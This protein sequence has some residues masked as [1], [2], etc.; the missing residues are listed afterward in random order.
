MLNGDAC[1]VCVCMYVCTCVC[2]WCLVILPL[3]IP[4]PVEAPGVLCTGLHLLQL[5][6]AGEHLLAAACEAPL[7]DGGCVAASWHV[8]H[9]GI[10]LIF[11]YPA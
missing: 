7:V 6:G 10:V 11:M 2:L 9:M 5:E 4:I 8:A 1:D 3:A